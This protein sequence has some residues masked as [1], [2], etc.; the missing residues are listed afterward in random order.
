MGSASQTVKTIR[1]KIKRVKKRR[2]S[3][4]TMNK[5]KLVMDSNKHML[6]YVEIIPGESSSLWQNYFSAFSY[7]RKLRVKFTFVAT[8]NDSKSRHKTRFVVVREKKIISRNWTLGSCGREARR[9]ARLMT[10]I[11][12]TQKIFKSSP[13]QSLKLIIVNLSGLVLGGPA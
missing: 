7:Q 1:A 12:L 11:L 6:N 13:S 8:T 4:M 10:W 2:D 5:R 9:R 3:V